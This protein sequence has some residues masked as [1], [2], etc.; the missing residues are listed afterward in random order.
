M[1][2]GL[3]NGGAFQIVVL[4]GLLPENLFSISTCV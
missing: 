4:A 2:A 1:N 3:T